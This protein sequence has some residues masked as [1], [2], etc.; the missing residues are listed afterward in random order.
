M[1]LTK[2]EKLHY[3][4]FEHRINAQGFIGSLTKL[5]F[6]LLRYRYSPIDSL[7]K[8]VPFC[9]VN[10]KVKREKPTFFFF[11]QSSMFGIL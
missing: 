11:I 10:P 3:N 6:G 2:Q 7:Q 5:S 1:A 8:L 9:G 4:V